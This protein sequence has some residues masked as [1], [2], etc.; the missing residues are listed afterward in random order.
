MPLILALVMLV[1]V[2]LTMCGSENGGKDWKSAEFPTLKTCL[3]GIKKATDSELNVVTD[4]PDS[5]SGRLVR[6]NGA[7]MCTMKE[8][9][10]KGIYFEAAFE[11]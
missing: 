3:D 5:V 11:E 6:T 9:G 7:F 10:T 2:G 1:I 4:K 8:T